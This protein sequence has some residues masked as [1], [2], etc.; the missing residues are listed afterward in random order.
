MHARRVWAVTLGLAFAAAMISSPSSSAM[1]SVNGGQNTGSGVATRVVGGVAADRTSTG[2]FMQCTPKVG[3]QTSLCAATA[4]SRWWAITAAH[5]VTS[6]SGRLKSRISTGPG[7]SY[8]QSN[9]EA[10]NAG[11]RHWIDR[12]VVNPRYT[13]GPFHWN[14]LA[15][16]H[17]TTAMTKEVLPLNIDAAFPATATP[18]QVFGFGTTADGDY[19]SL[20]RVLRMG[21]VKDLAGTNGSCGTYGGVYN[22][23]AQLCA[24]IEAGGI[25]SCQGDS[26]GPLTAMVGDRRVLVGVVSSGEGCA[27]AGYPGLYT[28]ISTY[29]A[30]IDRLVHPQPTWRYTWPCKR[31]ICNVGNGMAVRVKIKNTS[32]LRGAWSVTA[33]SS[34]VRVSKSKGSLPGYWTASIW[35]QAR[36]SAKTCTPLT[37]TAAGRSP[38]SQ[39]LRLNGARC[40]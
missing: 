34:V 31:A 19:T 25:D 13:Y 5:C 3:A 23:R 40:A 33:D 17:T 39:V 21:S 1:A 26:G 38:A 27:E 8:L 37:I 35:V 2:W 29:S 30:W 20:S 36:G 7:N 24:G 14:D 6:K 9:P 18:E 15:L 11:T 28:R 22:N 32:G 4:L 12:I 16:L 10:R